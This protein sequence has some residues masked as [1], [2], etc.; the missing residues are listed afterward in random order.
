[1]VKEDKMYVCATIRKSVVEKRSLKKSDLL[2]ISNRLNLDEKSLSEVV[3]IKERSL[4][5]IESRVIYFKK[6]NTGYKILEYL[7]IKKRV[8]LVF[9]YYIKHRF[10]L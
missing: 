6:V 1:M 3:K 7:E 4:D 2:L 10:K 5:Y 8:S 9:D